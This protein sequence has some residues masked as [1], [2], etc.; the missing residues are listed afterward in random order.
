MEVLNE[1][2]KRKTSPSNKIDAFLAEDWVLSPRVSFWH[3]ESSFFS[4]HVQILLLVRDPHLRHCYFFF[5]HFIS[6]IYFF[7]LAL[8]YL[9]LS[10]L[11]IIRSSQIYTLIVGEKKIRLVF[12]PLLPLWFLTQ[13]MNHFSKSLHFALKRCFSYV[14]ERISCWHMVCM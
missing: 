13:A 5:I 1:I 11:F 6:Y 10:L 7:Y 14:F 12:V 4:R 8:F 9:L 2:L 3:Q